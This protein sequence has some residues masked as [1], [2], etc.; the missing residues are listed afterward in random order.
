MLLSFAVRLIDTGRYKGNIKRAVATMPRSSSSKEDRPVRAAARK[1]QRQE[2]ASDSAT[3][4]PP[5]ARRA[6]SPRTSSPGAQLEKWGDYTLK[7]QDDNTGS[8]YIHP[9]ALRFTLNIVED[10]ARDTTTSVSKSLKDDG[11]LVRVTFIVVTT[12][13]STF[14]D[15]FFS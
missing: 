7:Y 12:C 4:E 3:D 5:R 2:Q 9:T 10:L 6:R 11:E 13:H 15:A 14:I 8:R 1:R